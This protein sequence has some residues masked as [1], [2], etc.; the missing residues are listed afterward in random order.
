[1]RSIIHAQL[2]WLL[3]KI[4]LNSGLKQL[5]AFCM[6]GGMASLVNYLVL[7]FIVEMFHWHPLIANI[8]AFFVAYQVSFFGH[9][10]LT[11]RYAVI[12]SK[13]LVWVKF[14][15][16]AGFSF[17]LNEAFFAFY[18]VLIPYYQIALLLTLI[19]IPPI[20]FVLAKIWAFK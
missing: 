20:T 19:T 13:Y 14:L 6:I 18:L 17:V 8:I 9:H 4:H 5:L 3:K 7:I 10:H 1:M 2:S 12:S 16:V 15:A 11:F